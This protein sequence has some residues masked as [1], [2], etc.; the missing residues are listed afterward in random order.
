MLVLMATAIAA[1]R[2]M[3]RKLVITLWVI[4]LIAMLGLFKYHVSSPLH[5]NF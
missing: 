5:L 1:Y 3:S 2:G 4:G